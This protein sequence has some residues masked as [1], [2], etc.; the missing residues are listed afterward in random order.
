MSIMQTYLIVSPNEK[1]IDLT[2]KK[3]TNKLTINELN[4]TVIIPDNSFTIME[5][6]SI[7]K[8]LIEKPFGGGNRLVIIKQIEKATLEA[9][10]ALLKILEEP[11]PTTF[12]ILTTSNTNKIIPTILSRCQI[13]NEIN[14]TDMMKEK[15]AE[16]IGLFLKSLITLSSAERMN[17]WPKSIKSKDDA[18]P[19]LNNIIIFLDRNLKT[20][21]EELSSKRDLSQM[22]VKSSA[23]LMYIESNVNYKATLDILFWGFPYGNRPSNHLLSRKT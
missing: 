22:I 3:I 18:K 8:L 16:K 9:S 14:S 20:D 21:N 19:F 10:N 2:I 17:F 6:R 13:I 15:T 4:L 7:K 23:A 11:P 1:F 5:S 12:F